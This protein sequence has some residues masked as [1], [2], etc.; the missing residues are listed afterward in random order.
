MSLP[1]ET[2]PSA[3]FV[4]SPCPGSPGS[5]IPCGCPLA[6]E[7]NPP[8][9]LICPDHSSWT[10]RAAGRGSLPCDGRRR[11]TQR[12]RPLYV[13]LEAQHPADFGR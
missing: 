8:H 1:E 11:A 4:Y 2:A 6:T 10:Q 12:S 7:A 9:R 3:V 13:G 5:P